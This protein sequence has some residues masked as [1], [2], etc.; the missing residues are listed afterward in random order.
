[1]NQTELTE[2]GRDVY[3]HDER[4]INLH[5][6]RTYRDQDGKLYVLSRTLDGIPPFFEAYGPYREDHCGILPR[7]RVNGQKHWGDGWSWEKAVTAFCRELDAVI[8]PARKS[9]ELKETQDR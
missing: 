8:V 5:S 2:I 6:E 3:G 1:M 4:A 7:L 9:P